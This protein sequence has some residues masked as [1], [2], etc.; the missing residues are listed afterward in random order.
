MQTELINLGTNQSLA[1]LASGILPIDVE[2]EMV[3]SLMILH[4]RA[5]HRKLSSRLLPSISEIFHVEFKS[6]FAVT[7]LKDLINYTIV[8]I[9]V[10]QRSNWTGQWS[11]YGGM[12]FFRRAV[13]NIGEENK[14]FS[15]IL[16]DVPIS[17]PHHKISVFCILNILQRSVIRTLR[18]T[19]GRKCCCCANRR[20]DHAYY[21]NPLHPVFSFP[22]HLRQIFVSALSSV[23]RR[24]GL[25]PGGSGMKMF[26]LVMVCLSLFLAALFLLFL[27]F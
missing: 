23:Q 5:I 12:N 22:R 21:A 15:A 1:S 6:N 10:Q 16:V 11:A 19:R 7:P 13:S 9:R 3:V 17:L 27:L 18:H 26:Y 24:R 20:C 2:S 4:R 14:S 8:H 25:I